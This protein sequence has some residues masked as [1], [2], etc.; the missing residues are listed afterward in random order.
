MK[1][2]DFIKNKDMPISELLTKCDICVHDSPIGCK[3]HSVNNKTA[4]VHNYHSRGSSG[5]RIFK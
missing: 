4:L 5:K 3:I 2:D 1:C